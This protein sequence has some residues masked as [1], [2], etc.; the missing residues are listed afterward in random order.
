MAK[1]GDITDV[2]LGWMIDLVSWI[3]NAIVKLVM[4][5]IGGLFGLIGKGFKALFNKGEG[6]QSDN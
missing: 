2:M 5:I 3:F 6:A 1:D 4:I